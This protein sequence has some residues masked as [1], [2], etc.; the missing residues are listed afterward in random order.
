MTHEADTFHEARNRVKT[1]AGDSPEQTDDFHRSLELLL[2]EDEDALT[3]VVQEGLRVTTWLDNDGAVERARERG[4]P[5]SHSQTIVGTASY[6]YGFMC[7]YYYRVVQD[8][9]S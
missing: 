1:L 7:G 5:E 6:A 8:E 2:G 3:L 4:L 9:R